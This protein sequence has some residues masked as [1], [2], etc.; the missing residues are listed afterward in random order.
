M[1]NWLN[2]RYENVFAFIEAGIREGD[3]APGSRLA[4]ERKL[5]EQLGI[6]RETVRLGLDLAEQSG[7]IVR[8]PQRG[9][10]VASPKVNQDLGVMQPFRET[11]L[12]MN[13]K[14][15][16]LLRNKEPV[17]LNAETAQKLQVEAGTPALQLEVLGLANGLPLALYRSTLPQWV[18]ESIGEDAPWGERSSYE[19]AATALKIASLTVSQELEAITLRRDLA[20]IVKTRA[21]SPGFSAVSIFSS[22]QGTPVELRHA[23]YPGSRFRF[24]VS[25]VINSFGG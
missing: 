11:V 10:F 8:I 9:T 25:R 18:V 23:W 24:K 2:T 17:I 5:A 21:G 16:Y 19:L 14:P 15:T 12:G 20:Q 22:P 7:L 3:L 6:S 1:S 13:M 4:G